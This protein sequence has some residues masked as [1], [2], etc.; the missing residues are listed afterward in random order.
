MTTGL[1]ILFLCPVPYSEKSLPAIQ[2]ETP[3]SQLHAI[4]LGSI[5]GHW[6]QQ[7][8]ILLNSPYMQGKQGGS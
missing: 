3:L 8:T 6:R 7:I 4:S 2:S 1:G 5:A